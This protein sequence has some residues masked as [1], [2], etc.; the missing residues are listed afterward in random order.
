MQIERFNTNQSAV[1]HRCRLS[2]HTRGNL[3]DPYLVSWMPAVIS[4]ADRFG[5]CTLAWSCV[6]QIDNLIFLCHIQLIWQLQLRLGLAVLLV[7]YSLLLHWKMS[8]TKCILYTLVLYARWLKCNGLCRR[9]FSTCTSSS[10]YCIPVSYAG[11]KL[12]RYASS[13][14]L[15]SMFTFSAAIVRRASVSLNRLEYVQNG[16]LRNASYWIPVNTYVVR[17]R[18]PTVHIIWIVCWWY[19]FVICAALLI[20]IS[21][22]L[23]WLSNHIPF[24]FTCLS[25]IW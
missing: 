1:P 21:V 4:F 25:T 10:M 18:I 20:L 24:E 3:R 6:I 14:F 7:K 8:I 11:Y 2:M 12:N 9:T 23:Q 19:G 15:L 13:H 5:Q 16:N 22:N 17:L